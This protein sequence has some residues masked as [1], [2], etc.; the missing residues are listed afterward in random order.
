MTA[1]DTGICAPESIATLLLQQGQLKRRA[2]AVQMFPRGTS[3]LALPDGFGRHE[4][5]RGVFHFA[6]EAIS[7][8]E[9]DR[10][11]AE[12]RENEFLLLGPFSKSDLAKRVLDGEQVTCI[13]EYSSDDVEVRC[14]AGTSGTIVE[15]REYFEKTKEPNGVIVIGEYPDRVRRA[16]GN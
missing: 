14:A 1:L 9:I 11:S 16:Y 13:T 7:P 8:S 6:P 4:N 12:G 5:T 2:R 15:Q 10:L 3:E